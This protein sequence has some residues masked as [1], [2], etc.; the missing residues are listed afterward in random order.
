MTTTRAALAFILLLAASASAQPG[1]QAGAQAGAQ[2]GTTFELADDG[3]VPAWLVVGPFEQPTT[4]FGTPGDSDDIGVATAAPVEGETVASASVAGGA[5]RWTPVH[6]DARG[7]TDFHASMGW[8]LPGVGPE[9]IW[10]AKAGY[11][12]VTL[13]SPAVQEVLL[14]TGSNSRLRIALNGQE[15]YAV[16]ADRNASP[17]SDT[18]RVRLEA[19]PNRLVVKVG[20]SHRNE[21]V[22]F[23][24]PLRWEWGF[25]ARVVRP[26]GRPADVRAVVPTRR[27]EPEVALVPTFYFKDGGA[28]LLQRFDLVVTSPGAEAV[29]GEAQVI[30]AGAT[31]RFSLGR[32]PFGQSRHALFLPEVT[33][34]QSARLAVRLGGT[35]AVSDVALT[36]Q[37]KVEL[38]LM[39]TSHT[40][41]GYTDPQ[42]VVV[43]KHVQTLDR[44]LELAEAHADFRWTVEATWP[45]A[46]YERSRPPETFARLMALVREGRVAVSP[47]YANP[48]TG[49]VSEEE[50]V[51]SFATAEN[52]AERYGIT[53]PAALYNDVPGFAWLLPAVLREAGAP[54]LVAGLNEAFN[55]YGFQRTLPKAFWWEGGDG[56]RV[57]TYRTESYN[58]GQ[59]YGMVKGVPAMEQRMWERLH[60]LAGS[61]PV[62]GLV[63]VNTTFSDNGGVPEAEFFAARAWN[64]AYAYPRVVVSTLG[65]FADAFTRRYGDD[66]PTVRGD[67][68]STWDVLGQGEL[69]R[70]V[71]QRRAQHQLPTAEALATIGW[72]V[73]ERQSPLRAEV[74]AAYEALQRYSGHGSGLEYGYGS[75]EE[76]ALTMA[77]R[78]SYV[79]SALLATEAVQ[80]RALYRLV[81]P[82][83]AF[84]TEGLYVFNGLS[85]ARDVPV[86]VEFPEPSTQRYSVV[87]GAT[88]AVVPS[89]HDGYTLRFVARG[90]PALGY[91]KLRLVARDASAMSLPSD[92]VAGEQTIE[93]AHYR[94]VVSAATGAVTSL[95]DKGTGHEMVEAHS[96]LPFGVPVR[97]LFPGEGGFEVVPSENVRVS[98]QD[99]RPARLVLSVHRAGAVVAR[100]D[101]VLW[102]SV[103]RVDVTHV[104]DLAR[105]SVPET[106]EEYAVAFPFALADAQARIETLGG[107]LDPQRD[108]FEAVD[109]DAFSV[110]RSVGLSGGGQSVS[111]AAVDS[112]VVR[113]RERDG[114]PPTLIATLVNN[115]PDD[116]NRRDERTG[117]WPLRFSFTG[118]AGAFDPARTSRFGYNAATAPAVRH[119]WLRAAEPEHSF[120]QVDGDQ[121]VLLALLPAD[122]GVGVLVR[123]MNVDPTRP[124]TARVSS[125]LLA[126]DT[127][128]R[129]PPREGAGG[130]RSVGGTLEVPLAPSEI[131]TLYVSR[132][133]AAPLP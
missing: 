103:D 129:L 53:S 126:L 52:L 106:M 55:G 80:E 7:F 130:V 41:I 10:W 24:D 84:E 25:F 110:R 77:F 108:R 75:P 92:L 28:G 60:R 72:L 76:N 16:D 118:H 81:R 85:W 131:V 133:A 30:A 17:G 111:W 14:L 102:E 91:R 18:V 125:P 50:L 116:W 29:E 82:E 4:G 78:E 5:V 124:A 39:L 68:T 97:Q 94:L 112:R 120:L 61:G 2:A 20:Q 37:P 117:T 59:T 19:G 128:R 36:P 9:K 113:W 122:D 119:T 48:F 27:T 51:R 101:Y 121:V 31:H 33:A 11:A 43:E 79:Q 23:F 57:L 56:S 21:G 26:D 38:H 8:A 69:G 15:V 83:E 123:L 104:V 88:G 35:E 54:F 99:E 107:F 67:W 89:V 96:G 93:N 100:T 86:E 45:L 58:E 65:D 109:H 63:L 6:T 46:E 62:P 127:A 90:L 87:D 132:A 73:D 22:Q 49:W 44:V 95:T 13:E 40:D 66:L 98:V 105:L 115:F 42:P 64:A 71:R 1:T 74:A 47:L 34:P 32:V 114:G 3:T 70:V 12:F